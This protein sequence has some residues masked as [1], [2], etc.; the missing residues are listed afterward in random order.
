MKF[1]STG[2]VDRNKITYTSTNGALLGTCVYNEEY[3]GLCF[4]LPDYLKG[5]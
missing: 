2:N 5:T 1:F 4:E 3:N